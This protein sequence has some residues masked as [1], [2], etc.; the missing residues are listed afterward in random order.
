MFQYF[1]LDNKG[2]ISCNNIKETFARCGNN[3]TLEDVRSMIKEL[4]P[5][6]NAMEV[7]LDMFVGLMSVENFMVKK[8][9]D[10]DNE[11]ARSFGTNLGEGR[12]SHHH[13]RMIGQD[14]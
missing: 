6:A 10:D 13:M 7:S 1:D 14:F 12:G 4:D 8:K 3:I 2:A 11:S 9:N 5:D